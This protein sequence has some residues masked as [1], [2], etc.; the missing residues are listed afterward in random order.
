MEGVGPQEAVKIP[1]LI[2]RVGSAA[3]P[4]LASS[5]PLTSRIARVST[6]I[7]LNL[8]LCHKIP[9]CLQEH[10]AGK[11]FQIFACPFAPH[12]ALLV[13]EEVMTFG[14][15]RF[16]ALWVSHVVVADS[17]HVGIIAE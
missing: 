2:G 4:P 7:S 9:Y 10:L 5:A 17:L 13:N 6:F 15:C 1:I 14:D 11:D 16:G 8:A 3:I 12:D